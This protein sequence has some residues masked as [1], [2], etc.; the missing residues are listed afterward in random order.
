MRRLHTQTKGRRIMPKVAIK[1]RGFV[2]TAL[3]ASYCSLPWL[4]RHSL[5]MPSG[6]R[7][8]RSVDWNTGDNWTAATPP[9]NAGDTA[10]FNTSTMTSLFLSGDRHHRFHDVQLGRETL[11]R[12]HER[13]GHSFSFVGV[14]IVNNSARR[15]RLRTTSVA[16]LTS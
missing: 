15:R 13:T 2:A 16:P 5:W 14:G 3:G 12:C 10:T 8:R 7:I 6:I 9:V 4:L 1:N 11:S